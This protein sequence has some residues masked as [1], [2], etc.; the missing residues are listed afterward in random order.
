MLSLYPPLQ[1]EG[2][3]RSER[4]GVA[5]L[6]HPTPDRI[7]LRSM[8]SVPPPAGEGEVRAWRSPAFHSRRLAHAPEEWERAFDHAAEILAPGLVGEEEAG[9]RIDD[10]VERGLV[11]ALDRG[12]LVVEV[13]CVEP[14]RDLGFGL[15]VLG[16]AE[17]GL[18]AVGAD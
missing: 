5:A 7:S 15:V 12:L 17:P 14:S 18:V 9:G 10:G 4:G 11:D 3:E 8:R 2:R 16:P 6:P 1:G 13:F